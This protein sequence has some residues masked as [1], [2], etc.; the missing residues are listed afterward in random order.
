MKKISGELGER[1]PRNKYNDMDKARLSYA[2]Q[3]KPGKNATGKLQ[4]RLLRLL[5]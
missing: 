2:W 3:R 1:M 4:R 5:A